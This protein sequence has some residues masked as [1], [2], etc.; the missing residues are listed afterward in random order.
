MVIG[1]VPRGTEVFSD[2]LCLRHSP[3]RVFSF[4]HLTLKSSCELLFVQGQRGDVGMFC[5]LH[6]G[7][8]F[9]GSF[10]EESVFSSACICGA[11][12]ENQVYGCVGLFLGLYLVVYV[13]EPIACWLCSYGSIVLFE[14][15][16]R[17]PPAGFFCSGLS[18]LFWV[19]GTSI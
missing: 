10:V 7:I 5:L 2:R 9:P 12:V 3:S 6:V 15:R 13:D 14:I 17:D 18:W 4:P 16:N 19:L 1:V 11:S 8:Q